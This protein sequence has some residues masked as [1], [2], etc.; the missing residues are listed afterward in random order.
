MD[1]ECYVRIGVQSRRGVLTFTGGISD[2]HEIISPCAQEAKLLKNY[3]FIPLT[4][5]NKL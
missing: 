1:G 2:S 3:N 4:S 5:M